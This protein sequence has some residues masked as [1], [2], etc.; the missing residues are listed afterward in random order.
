MSSLLSLPPHSHPTPLDHHR[1]T[2]W[3]PCVKQQLPTSYLFYTWWMNKDLVHKYNR[4]LLSHK[5]EQI[6]VSCSAVDEPRA[7]IQREVSQKE[8]N[9]YYHDFSCWAGKKIFLRKSLRT[10][11]GFLYHSVGK[12]SACSMGDVGSTW[13]R[14]IPWRREWQPTPGFLP[15]ESHGQRSLAGY[16]SWCHKSQTQLSAIFLLSLRTGQ[17]RTRTKGWRRKVH[18]KHSE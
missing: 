9:R 5:K 17:D 15:G 14:K 4:I 1:D 8:N 11:W 6:W 16:T 18:R 12:A 13:V 3:G 10:G 2:G 7:C